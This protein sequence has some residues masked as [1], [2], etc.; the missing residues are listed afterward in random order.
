[1]QKKAPVNSFEFD[2]QIVIQVRTETEDGATGAKLAT[3]GTHATV[4]ARVRESAT[5]AGLSS[6]GP[7]ETYARPHEVLIRWRDDFDKSSMRISYGGRILRVIGNAEVGRREAIKLTCQE[8]A[9]E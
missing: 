7:M 5:A 1:M 8:W 9:H 3:W 2:R 4:W 6:S